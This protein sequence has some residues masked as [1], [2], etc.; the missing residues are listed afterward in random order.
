MLRHLVRFARPHALTASAR[1]Y[2]SGQ[3]HGIAAFDGRIILP[4][5]SPPRWHPVAEGRPDRHGIASIAILV[6]RA[7]PRGQIRVPG[8]I[9]HHLAQN[10]G[11]P[12]RQD[13]HRADDLVSA[14]DTRRGRAGGQYRDAGLECSLEHADLLGQAAPVDMSVILP[15]EGLEK[16]RLATEPVV[17]DAA[18]G[19]RA[20]HVAVLL[21]EDRIRPLA[22]R[23]DRGREAA[24]AAAHDEDVAFR[25]DRQHNVSNRDLCPWGVQQRSIAE[26]HLPIC[27][28]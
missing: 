15:V 21:H 20:A 17:P 12:A 25:Q 6:G 16:L 13:H 7:S 14:P 10:G 3:V 19:A 22:R 11:R 4:R 5:R 26:E 18:H 23:G 9:D 28:R 2:R 24:R 27:R 8:R 1:D